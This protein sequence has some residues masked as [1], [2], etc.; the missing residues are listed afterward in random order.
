MA[1]PVTS[2]VDD[3]APLDHGVD[4]GPGDQPVGEVGHRQARQDRDPHPGGHQ[5]EDRAVVVEARGVAGVNPAAVQ[6]PRPIRPMGL[7]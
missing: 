6:A 3:D 7:S 2:G 1:A 4:E 5:P